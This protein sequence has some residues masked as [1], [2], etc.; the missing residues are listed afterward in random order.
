[1]LLNRPEF[2]GDPG[3]TVTL[4]GQFKI[5]GPTGSLLT[6]LRVIEARPG[7]TAGDGSPADFGHSALL[8]SSRSQVKGMNPS[9]GE[10]TP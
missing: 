5:W 1:M 9:E 4:T 2:D 8:V 7:P 10:G 3:V 6:G